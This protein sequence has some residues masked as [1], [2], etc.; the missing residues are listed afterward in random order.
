MRHGESKSLVERIHKPYGDI[1]V[2]HQYRCRVENGWKHFLISRD[3]KK[4]HLCDRYNE[5]CDAVCHTRNV[6]C[7]VNQAKKSIEV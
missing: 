5:P 3:D 1:T 4:V 2:G 6:V 7:Y